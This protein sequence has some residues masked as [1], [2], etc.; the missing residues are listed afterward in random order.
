MDATVE[1]NRPVSNSSPEATHTSLQLKNRVKLRRGA[2]LDEMSNLKSASNPVEK[3]HPII[4]E[5]TP[6]RRNGN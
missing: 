3:T 1:I 2:T 6:S 4:A 5:K